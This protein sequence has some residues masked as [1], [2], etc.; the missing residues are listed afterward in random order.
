MIDGMRLWRPWKGFS[1][2]QL[3]LDQE[4][5]WYFLS[6]PFDVLP[7]FTS[8]REDV[9]RDGALGATV[10]K[11]GQFV[12]CIELSVHSVLFSVHVLHA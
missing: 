9:P 2:F 6:V 5:N 11:C 12:T 8:S 3:K 10:C 4:T 1:C 7:Y